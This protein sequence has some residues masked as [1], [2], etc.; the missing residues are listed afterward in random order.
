MSSCLH[1]EYFDTDASSYT[2]RLKLPLKGPD[3]FRVG[4]ANILHVDHADGTTHFV[5]LSN[6]RRYYATRSGDSSHTDNSSQES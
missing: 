6:V 1:I 2:H 3:S 4:E 5:P